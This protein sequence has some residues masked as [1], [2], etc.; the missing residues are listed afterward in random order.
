MAE[1]GDTHLSPDGAVNPRPG[2]WFPYN[3]LTKL[4]KNEVPAQGVSASGGLRRWRCWNPRSIGNT[5]LTAFG[6]RKRW[7]PRTSRPCLRLRLPGRRAPRKPSVWRKARADY[8][9]RSRALLHLHF[10]PS[11]RRR[12]ALRRQVFCLQPVKEL[13]QSFFQTLGFKR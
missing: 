12:L 4:L 9:N 5:R 8:V 11:R 3:F 1:N 2:I 13:L 7:L 6:L 10:C